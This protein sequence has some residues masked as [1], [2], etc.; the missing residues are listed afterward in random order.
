[1][2]RFALLSGLLLITGVASA[3]VY[4]WT[5]SQGTV[6]Y[7]ESA[8]PQGTKFKRIHTNGSAEPL[9]APPPKP[10][11]DA[12]AGGS[13]EPGAQAP[14]ADTPENRTKLCNSLKSNLTALQGKGPVV[15]EQGGK[16]KALDAAE[17]KQQVST[18]QSQYNQYC[19][20]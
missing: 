14:V 12:P 2:L 13:L 8:P 11:A 6:H 18:A 16:P 15:M 3:Q 5:D 1:M 9:E 7:S 19:K 10:V 17:R 4:K 20:E